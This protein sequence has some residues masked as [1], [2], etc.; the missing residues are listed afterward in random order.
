M[1]IKIDRYEI[2]FIGWCRG[3]FLALAGRLARLG[4]RTNSRPRRLEEGHGTYCLS[5]ID[6]R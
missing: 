2:L 1:A 4:F 3:V 6:A 5:K